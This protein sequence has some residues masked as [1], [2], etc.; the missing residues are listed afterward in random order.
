M[1]DDG[2]L[3]APYCYHLPPSID[4]VEVFQWFHRIDHHLVCEIFTLSSKSILY[5]AAQ[6][7]LR[8][9]WGRPAATDRAGLAAMMRYLMDSLRWFEH[10]T[11]LVECHMLFMNHLEAGLSCIRFQPA[12]ERLLPADGTQLTAADVDLVVQPA[13]RSGSILT[14]E[15]SF[16]HC[17]AEEV[18]REK[19]V[20]R[21]VD[22]DSL[23]KLGRQG[24]S[25]SCGS[26]NAASNRRLRLGADAK[27]A[28]SVTLFVWAAVR[29]L[30]RRI[31]M[32]QEFPPDHPLFAPARP[33]E[34]PKIS[35]LGD[36][37]ETLLIQRKEITGRGL[38]LYCKG[39]WREALELFSQV[40]ALSL[41]G[42]EYQ[43]VM[44]QHRAGCHLHLQQYQPAVED[45]TA[46]LRR[47]PHAYVALHR[48]AQAY[49]ALGELESA[50]EDVMQLLRLYPGSSQGHEFH[51]R[52]AHLLFPHPEPQCH[53]PDPS[54]M[55]IKV[56]AIPSPGPPSTPPATE[57][58]WVPHAVA[59]D[60]VG[61]PLT[62]DPSSMDILSFGSDQLTFELATLPPHPDPLTVDD[63]PYLSAFLESGAALEY[64]VCRGK[65]LG[66]GAF[67]RVYRAVHPSGGWFMA[68]KEVEAKY[69]EEAQDLLGALELMST[70]KHK[71]IIR[72]MGLRR[73]PGFYH[74]VL[75]YCSGGSLRS[76][77]EELRG[78]SLSLIRKYA[79]E[80]LLGLRYIH[81]HGLL[82]R[83]IKAGNIL[84]RDD[85]TA[86]VADLGTCMRIPEGEPT[87][88]DSVKGT[89]LWM[90]PETFRGRYSTASDVWSFGCMLIEMATG[91]D[92]WHEQQFQEQLTAMVFIATRPDAL[93]AIPPPLNDHDL[94]RHFFHCCIARSP[95]ERCSADLLLRHPWLSCTEPNTPF[96][97][98]PTSPCAG[99]TKCSKSKFLDSNCGS[100]KR[101]TSSSVTESSL[102]DTTSSLPLLTSPHRVS[103][104]AIGTSLIDTSE[105][106]E[107]STLGV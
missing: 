43:Y 102:V 15:G 64:T 74:I 105:P 44:Y 87:R 97:P 26:G 67:G 93:P 103:D 63:P 94:G 79:T 28:Y 5:E 106:E 14:S 19:W 1:L 41:N 3:L 4:P 52:L 60:P 99:N 76:L 38:A 72:N 2:P 34:V 65:V 54:P 95:S 56:D 55:K 46:A 16:E 47:N 32:L 90:A 45:C 57:P 7:Y 91:K 62:T 96:S 24:S 69:L 35:S 49:E 6:Y 42:D 89:V 53:T 86:K 78:L 33:S 92:P 13:S 83:D 20:F 68:I 18:D 85:G 75:E 59:F 39:D 88:C 100:F 107:R 77:V 21:E 58:L 84:L 37:F 61:S 10:S 11:L 17:V 9:P 22:D 81:A 40:I 25:S 70:M 48:R 8:R 51:S 73:L 80:V 36:S 27:L 23:Q 71:N 98:F 30:A 82:H 29:L 50:M 31:E 66:R 12:L 104:S 101:T